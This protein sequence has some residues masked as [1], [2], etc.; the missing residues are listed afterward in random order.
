[1]VPPH[2]VL[3]LPVSPPP[4]TIEFGI[5]LKA[6][7]LLS[8]WAKVGM[9]GAAGGLFIIGISPR[10][11]L[12]RRCGWNTAPRRREYNL[13]FSRNV[14]FLWN[15]WRDAWCAPLQQLDAR[16]FLC[17]LRHTG[18][19]WSTVPSHQI[20]FYLSLS[21]QLSA[22]V[23]HPIT[24]VAFRT[25]KKDADS[26]FFSFIKTHFE[27]DYFLLDVAQC[28]E[29]VPP[30]KCH[31]D[32]G[33]GFSLEMWNWNDYQLFIWA[34]LG[35]QTLLHLHFNCCSFTCLLKHTRVLFKPPTSLSC[36]PWPKRPPIGTLQTEEWAKEAKQSVRSARVRWWRGLLRFLSAGCSFSASLASCVYVEKLGLSQGLKLQLRGC[37]TPMFTQHGVEEFT[38]QAVSRFW[39]RNR[40]MNPRQVYRE[41]SFQPALSPTPCATQAHLKLA[42]NPPTY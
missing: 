4:N 20:R 18:Q 22:S 1:M 36:E 41:L 24:R 30:Y 35:A 31:T 25:H 34:K 3:V 37:P 42:T 40:K 17:L 8:W 26:L 33:R 5:L 15:F 9:L 28:R 29:V 7:D 12:W 10:G 11:G 39:S 6:V 19:M 23:S 21:R 16:L 32:G 38:Q 2:A 27:A 14:F 13:F